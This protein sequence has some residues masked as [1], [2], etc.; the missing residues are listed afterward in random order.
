[1]LSMILSMLS[2]LAHL[3]KSVLTK[4]LVISNGI[5]S[6][7]VNH[8]VTFSHEN[9]TLNL[10]F[11]SRMNEL[12]TVV[13]IY[14]INRQMGNT[15]GEHERGPDLPETTRHRQTH[16]TSPFKPKNVLKMQKKTNVILW[17]SR[18]SFQISCST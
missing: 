15:F 2:S 10:K 12:P 9:F 6:S 1:M 16:E 17:F 5:L 7:I 18:S 13:E 3:P 4:N 14:R 8:C 11:N